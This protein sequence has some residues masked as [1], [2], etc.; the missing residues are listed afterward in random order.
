MKNKILILLGLALFVFAITMVSCNKEEENKR[1]VPDHDSARI[2]F[3]SYFQ[4]AERRADIFWRACDRAYQTNPD[5][6]MTAC[7]MNDFDGFKRITQLDDA[8]FEELKD[9]IVQAQA[10]IERDH[11]GITS[12]YM[13]TSCSECSGKVLQKVG[14]YVQTHNGQAALVDK[15]EPADC[16]FICSMACMSTLELFVPCVLTCVKMCNVYFNLWFL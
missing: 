13:E 2:D 12:K 8:F 6:F 3:G 7:E 15:L 4:D 5:Q 10:R 9:D 1:Y 14:R 16:W 11:P